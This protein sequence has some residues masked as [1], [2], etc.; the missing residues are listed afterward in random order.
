MLALKHCIVEKRT[1]LLLLCFHLVVQ[2]AFFSISFD[3][4]KF[5]CKIFYEVILLRLVDRLALVGDICDLFANLSGVLHFFF[6]FMF[7]LY[8]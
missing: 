4:K 8:T 2:F 5:L 3:T 1:G 6:L 7:E